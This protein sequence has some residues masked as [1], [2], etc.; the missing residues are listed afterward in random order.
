MNTDELRGLIYNN[1]ESSKLDFKIKIHEIKPEKPT[2]KNK[3]NEWVKNKEEQWAELVKDVISLVNGNVGTHEKTGYLIVGAADQLKPDGTRYLRD[4]MSEE[5]PTQSEML[6]KLNSYCYPNLPG[7]ECYEK[8]LD[9]KT[10]F[11][12]EIPPSPYL[13][14]LS[15][16]LKTPKKE[17]SPYVLL[18]RRPDGEKIYEASPEE[19]E[20]LQQEKRKPI[21]GENMT[22]EQREIAAGDT[23]EEVLQVYF[24][25]LSV[26]LVDKNLLAIA[27]KGNQATAEE[28]ELLAS[29]MNVIRARTLSILR[30]F[31]NDSERKTSVIQFLIEADFVSKL[32]LNLRG[33]TLSGVNLSGTNIEDVDLSNANLSRVNLVYAHLS[34]ANLFRANLSHSNLTGTDL[35]C[36]DLFYA[37]FRGANLSNANLSRTNLRGADFSDAD[38]S[39]ADLSDSDLLNADLSNANNLKYDQLITAKLCNTKLPEG[40]TISSNRDCQELRTED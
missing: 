1:R 30:R 10:L 16:Q 33:A 32:K 38:L 7:I 25:R 8:A 24:D 12:I 9:G 20:I 17:F 19:Q 34:H 21:Q 31:E 35:F 23:K 5:L 22:E 27:A 29:A 37:I 14:R 11:I 3:E 15:R 26:L 40:I 36:A 6:D 2:E 18:I 28:R 4:V 39:D 13:H